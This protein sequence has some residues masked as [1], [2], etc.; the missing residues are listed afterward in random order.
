MAQ[1]Y[2]TDKELAIY[3]NETK[4]RIY[5]LERKL[6]KKKLSPIRTIRVFIDPS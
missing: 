6:G 3:F 2:F 5:Q 4:K 1:E